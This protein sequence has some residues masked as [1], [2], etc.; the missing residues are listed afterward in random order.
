MTEKEP[1]LDPAFRLQNVRTTLVHDGV[2]G[3]AEPADT[4]ASAKS[5]AIQGGLTP[6]LS[7]VR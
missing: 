1:I 2:F 6:L 4:E 3:Y 7:A 5:G